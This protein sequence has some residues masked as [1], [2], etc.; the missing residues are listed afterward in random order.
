MDLIL[1]LPLGR[2]WRR[3]SRALLSSSR[4]PQ[5]KEK[6]PSD[7]W[8]NSCRKKRQRNSVSMMRCTVSCIC[9]FSLYVL[10]CTC[11]CTRIRAWIYWLPEHLGLRY[12]LR[13]IC[14]N[15]R[16]C[17]CTCLFVTQIHA[18]CESAVACTLHGQCWVV[19]QRHH[20][21]VIMCMSFFLQLCR[22]ARS[23]LAILQ[24]CKVFPWNYAEMQGLFLQFC[25]DARIFLAIVQRCKVFPCDSAE[26]QCLFSN[27]GASLR[28]IQEETVP[29]VFFERWRGDFETDSCW[30]EK[31]CW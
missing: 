11:V 27:V 13:I 4:A 15:V 7:S 10:S 25:R 20:P 14:S 8:I 29:R 2:L 6:S 5:S 17:A 18:S 30:D 23:F 31:W 22:D 16:M 28:I 9:V 1:H 19:L 24:R 21:P 3:G 12:Y 26:V